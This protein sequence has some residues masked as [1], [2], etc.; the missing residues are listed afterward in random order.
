MFSD[1]TAKVFFYDQLF[2]QLGSLSLWRAK[3]F[4]F[5][6]YST[7]V[8]APKIEG[9]IVLFN[10]TSYDVEGANQGCPLALVSLWACMP[11]TCST[12]LSDSSR[13]VA[14]DNSSTEASTMGGTHNVWHRCG[15]WPW[16]TR[17][18]PEAMVGQRKGKGARS[19][20]DCEERVV[21]SRW[22]D[23][24]LVSE[25]NCRLA[26]TGRRRHPRRIRYKEPCM[27]CSKRMARF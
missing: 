9:S 1:P 3:L 6:R 13:P 5:S 10:R 12:S 20:S 22:W 19:N 21:V 16:T 8:I 7:T 14:E 18:P 4:I 27:R 25:R 15:A 23:P 2:H 11:S 17:S 26:R 24:P